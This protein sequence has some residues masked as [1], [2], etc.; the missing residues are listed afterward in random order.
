[1]NWTAEEELLDRRD[2]TLLQLTQIR[3]EI[4][5]CTQAAIDDRA[6]S[7][8]P[9]HNLHRKEEELLEE[10]AHVRTEIALL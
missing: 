4:S 5:S 7:D 1:M 3:Q 8:D 6:S 2:A 10:L 9:L